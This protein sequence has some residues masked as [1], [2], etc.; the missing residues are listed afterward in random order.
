MFF[1]SF[2][3]VGIEYR[4]VGL[5]IGSPV[6]EEFVVSRGQSVEISG[7]REAVVWQGVAE[8]GHITVEKRIFSLSGDASLIWSDRLY[9]QSGKSA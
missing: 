5:N 4:V 9:K 8:G 1:L 6:R 2:G 3:E 7:I